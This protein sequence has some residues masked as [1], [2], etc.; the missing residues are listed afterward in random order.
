MKRIVI[1]IVIV[2]LIFSVDLISQ[3]VKF[4]QIYGG[5]LEF[6][7]FS[8]TETPDGGYLLAG[9][10]STL[11]GSDYKIVKTDSLGNVQWINSGNRYDGSN[12]ESK[13]FSV[14]YLDN[15]YY[16]TG[17][18]VTDFS[19]F[20]PKAY[21]VKC[22]TLGNIIWDRIDS[23]LSSYGKRIVGSKDRNLLFTGF[24]ANNI[25]GIKYNSWFGKIDTSGTF[26]WSEVIPDTT[27]IYATDVVE[28]NN[29]F[30]VSSIAYRDTGSASIYG[31][32]LNCIDSLGNVYWNY[33]EK[34]TS[35]NGISNLIIDSAYIY[36]GQ[37]YASN[38]YSPNSYYSSIIKFDTSGNFIWRNDFSNLQFRGKGWNVYV[39]KT[40]DNNLFAV[41][42][43]LNIVKL[44]KN[45]TNIWQREQDT[46]F[47]ETQQSILN[48]KG[49]LVTTG[50]FHMSGML[51]VPFLVEYYDTTLTNMSSIQD[52]IKLNIFPNPFTTGI[53]IH[54]D[55]NGYGYVELYNLVGS[56]LTRFEII[57]GLNYIDL[58]KL[59]NGVYFLSVMNNNLTK[60]FKIIK[61]NNHF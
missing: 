49:N 35:Y 53:Y 29:R 38:S 33:T 45:G 2:L 32:I 47:Y 4:S 22:D 14:F 11:N 56:L 12:F 19:Q 17:M 18:I 6:Q 58:P 5:L 46:T 59:P 28:L 55:L 36:V 37:F 7:P 52:G 26:L 9:G 42:Q 21:F 57:N 60:V 44:D 34:D 39:T 15:Y 20:I 41:C 10:M 31:S 13:I 48:S 54:S 23:S 43:G 24:V 51:Q 61:N 50:Y 3:G 25:F 30:I 8:L 27:L 1:L 40:N 16:L